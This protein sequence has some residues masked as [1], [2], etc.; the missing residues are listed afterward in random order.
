MSTT[1]ETRKDIPDAPCYV[2]CNDSF[3]SGWGQATRMTN[4]CILPCESWEE[5]EI[6]A[7]NARNRADQKRVRIVGDKPRMRSHI[8]YSLFNRE[9]ASRWYKQGGFTAPNR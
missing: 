1:I 2:L 7:Q 4:T 9:D 8:L 5:A 6:V 3:M